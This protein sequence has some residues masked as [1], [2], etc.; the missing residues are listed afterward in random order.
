M[1]IHPCLL[2][3]KARMSLIRIL[4]PVWKCSSTL[5]RTCLTLKSTWFVIQTRDFSFYFLATGNGPTSIV[6]QCNMQMSRDCSKRT[7]GEESKWATLEQN[8]LLRVL[9]RTGPADY[10]RASGVCSSWRRTAVKNSSN[11]QL[12]LLLLHYDL[13][14]ENRAFY[15][16]LEHRKYEIR[17]KAFCGGLCCGS[18]AG[19]LI[20]AN[21][22][23]EVSLANPLS[24][25]EIQLP[26]LKTLSLP[27]KLRPT[28]ERLKRLG[29]LGFLSGATLST[30]PSD[31]N[32]VVA[33]LLDS[34][35]IVVCRPGDA[36]WTLV[37][38]DQPT[39]QY[40]DIISVNGC[41][42][43][44][45]MKGG[46]TVFDGE[47]NS[48]AERWNMGS[49]YRRSNHTENIYLV[50][51][52]EDLLMV[53]RSV[54]CCDLKSVRKK[55]F[56]YYLHTFRANIY[57]LSLSGKCWVE[58][59]NEIC[60]PGSG[61]TSDRTEVHENSNNS[62]QIDLN[63]PYSTESDD[64]LNVAGHGRRHESSGNSSQIDLNVSYSTE[65]DVARHR[66]ERS[67]D[68]RQIDLNVPYSTDSDEQSTRVDERITQR[69][70][71]MGKCNSCLLTQDGF[72]E[73]NKRSLQND[74]LKIFEQALSKNVTMLFPG[75]SKTSDR[76]CYRRSRCPPMWVTP[77]FW[78]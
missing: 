42:Y 25:A 10:R 18:S 28:P 71:F 15:S 66:H 37:V 34:K 27:T 23:G 58:V 44:L 8:L 20:L 39:I 77:N 72:P 40:C 31:R 13:N 41:F 11:T 70:L 26:S 63:V 45:D 1:N 73:L 74:E 5:I 33:G 46:L 36:A 30:V 32:C 52:S 54:R 76:P 67:S 61:R 19:W 12:P 65:S 24:G 55:K 49:S 48:K 68:S 35:K 60:W 9:K 38:E 69:L 3:S 78:S 17:L 56:P 4:L 6:L 22:D 53:E 51:S 47:P 2:V 75:A 29:I 64:G 50:V 16:L 21:G 7:S 43:A 14:S 62:S 59:V 57:K